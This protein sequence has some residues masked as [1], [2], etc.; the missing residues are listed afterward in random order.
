MIRFIPEEM[1]WTRVTA[2]VCKGSPPKEHFAH[3]ATMVEGRMVLFGGYGGRYFDD[4][5]TFNPERLEWVLEHTTG[6]KPRCAHTGISIGNHTFIFGGFDGKVQFNDFWVLDTDTM[7]WT[8]VVCESPPPPHCY[9]TSSVVG[10]KLYIFSGWDGNIRM[11][12][13]YVINTS[14]IKYNEVTKQMEGKWEAVKTHGTAPSKRAAATATV[15]QKKVYFFG[16]TNGDVMLADLH[17]LDTETMHCSVPEVSG[18][19]PP[20]IAYHSAVAI[21][22]KIFVFGGHNGGART[23]NVYMFDTQRLKWSYFKVKGQVPTP[24]SH[25]SAT[26]FQNKVILFGGYDGRSLF[27]DMFILD[28]KVPEVNF[29]AVHMK[30]FFRTE[31]FTDFDIVVEGRTFKTHK[32][33]LHARAPALLESEAIPSKVSAKS[34]DLFLEFVYT[35]NLPPD[36]DIEVVDLI[37]LLSLSIHFEQLYLEQLCYYLTSTMLTEDNV[38]EYAKPYEQYPIKKYGLFM[39]KWMIEHVSNAD[40][41]QNMKAEFDKLNIPE[42]EEDFSHDIIPRNEKI[43]GTALLKLF[44]EQVMT[45]FTL[46]IEDKNLKCHKAILAARCD[47]FA[48]L[49]RSGMT[50]CSKGTLVLKEPMTYACVEAIIEF[51]YSNDAEHIT[52][53]AMCKSI[54]E[55]QANYFCLFSEYGGPH[56]ALFR[57]CDEVIQN[58]SAETGRGRRRGVRD[59]NCTVM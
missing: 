5:Y 32:A 27:N 29:L 14:E 40:K 19:I 30:E 54:V 41:L 17:V 10:T 36:L 24:R 26:V 1:E 31:Q 45:D 43:V 59:K 16:G 21:S 46:V 42:L 49:F 4:L 55:D 34:F 50:E 48:C 22:S 2:D 44:K 52:S 53:S 37:S 38:L 47:Y 13:I 7:V 25:C 6:K 15:V 3:S 35:G 58:D 28:T 56:N 20:A 18:D 33:I 23:N 11:N 39:R 51:L 8:E 57:H 12:E 9:H